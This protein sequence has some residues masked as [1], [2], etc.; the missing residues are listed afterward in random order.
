MKST[1][2]FEG[3][4]TQEMGRYLAMNA[5]PWECRR[6]GVADFIPWRKHTKGKTPGITGREAMSSDLESD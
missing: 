1:M 5:D 3:V 6:W 4:N 2:K